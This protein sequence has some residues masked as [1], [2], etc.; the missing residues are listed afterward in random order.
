M[1]DVAN[2]LETLYRTRSIALRNA[3]ALVAGGYEEARDAGQEA[4]AIA[5]RERAGYR[6][7]G[8][9]EPWVFRI[10]LRLARRA[11]APLASLDSDALPAHALRGLSPRRRQMLFLRYFADDTG[12]RRAPASAHPGG[13]VAW[14]STRHTHRPSVPLPEGALHLSRPRFDL[15]ERPDGDRVGPT[16]R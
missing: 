10:A 7:D 8:P 13:G 15:H 11:K 4:F 12:T 3:L 2:D 5:L 1:S 6:G 16:Q 9:L 14:H